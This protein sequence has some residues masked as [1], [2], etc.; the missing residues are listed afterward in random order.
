[1]R[2]DDDKTI[3][4]LIREELEQGPELQIVETSNASVSHEEELERAFFAQGDHWNA[5]AEKRA[6]RSLPN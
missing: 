6:E 4:D 2:F 3:A 1:M 5:L